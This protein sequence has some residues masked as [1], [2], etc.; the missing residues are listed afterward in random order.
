MKKINGFYTHMVVF[1]AVV[2]GLIARNFSYDPHRL[3]SLWVAFGWGKGVA[4][5]AVRVF[6]LDNRPNK[7]RM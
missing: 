4:Y 1:I 3:W 2:T 7:A 5:H 6:Y